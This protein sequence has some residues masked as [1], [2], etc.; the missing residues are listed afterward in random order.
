MSPPP[1]RT[2]APFHGVTLGD[3]VTELGGRLEPDN[4]H[5][6][7]RPVR[8]VC[9]LDNPRLDHLGALL[10]PR[11]QRL[12]DTFHGAALL[13]HDEPT[14][15]SRRTDDVPRWLH[16][17]PHDVFDT[18]CLR[19]RRFGC[20]DP[21]LRHASAHVDP[22]ATLA[23]DVAIGHAAFIGAEVQVGQGTRIGHSAVL[24]PGC[25]LGA[26]CAIGAGAWLGP[27][28][29]L[30]DDV[31]IGPHA[32]IGAPGFGYR[33]D[34]RG[35]LV[36]H[37]HIGGVIVED[38]VHIGANTCIDAGRLEPTRIGARSRIDNLVHLAHNVRL[39]ERCIVL[40]QV[41]V[42]GSSVLEDDCILAGQA[43][44]AGHL[45]VGRGARVAAQA[46]VGRNVPPA[47]SVAGSPAFELAR[48]RRV[49]HL[50]RDLDERLRSL[51]QRLS[52][53]ESRR[54]EPA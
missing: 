44:V 20:G 27:G 34:A 41:G 54:G 38:E 5:S 29:W 28:T 14:D 21:S 23:S 30:G 37:P 25:R 45:R 10:D 13:V 48:W 52:A 11:Y 7:A 42:A 1:P 17:S 40:A 32:V 19:A 22:S 2:H 24:E 31:V 15:S 3:L 36:R 8:G 49:S 26:R 4:P 6:R 18:L 46:G 33:P 47:A 16:P 12:A 43:G 53:L 39:G 35:V 9:P 51:E 50:Q